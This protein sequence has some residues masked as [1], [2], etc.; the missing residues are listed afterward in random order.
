[1]KIAKILNQLFAFPFVMLIRFYQLFIS[2]HFGPRCRFVPTC[3]Q[4]ALESFKK[5]GAIKGFTL[6][7]KR[8]SK[9]HPWGSSGFDAVP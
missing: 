5:H 4:Y 2:P 3:S 1:M 9:C 8:L 7:I 6:T